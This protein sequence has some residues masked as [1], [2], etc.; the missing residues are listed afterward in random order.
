[1]VR[2][3]FDRTKRGFGPCHGLGGDCPQV[4]GKPHFYITYGDVLAGVLVAFLIGLAVA[5]R[6]VASPDSS[7]VRW[8]S[9]LVLVLVVVLGVWGLRKYRVVALKNGRPKGSGR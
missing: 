7:V 3:R 4:C 1:M 8:S 9:P 6:I 5:A 2:V